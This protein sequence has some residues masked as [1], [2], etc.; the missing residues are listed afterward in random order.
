MQLLSK[1]LSWVKPK[2]ASAQTSGTSST[3]CAEDTDSTA[4]KTSVD[5]EG[6]KAPSGSCLEVKLV[7][8]IYDIRNREWVTQDSAIPERKRSAV[9]EDKYG[10]Y[11]FTVVRK[12]D[13]RSDPADFLFKILLDIKSSQLKKACQEVIGN[14]KGISWTFTPLRVSCDWSCFLVICCS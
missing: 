1:L 4:V 8:E 10:K 6:D 12:F 13:K 2:Q 5:K 9:D 7:D 14:V 11:A 3:T